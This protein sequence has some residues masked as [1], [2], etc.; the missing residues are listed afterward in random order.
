MLHVCPRHH[1]NGSFQSSVMDSYWTRPRFIH[2][3]PTRPGKSTY[4]IFIL[5]SSFGRP[6][7]PGLSMM[8]SIVADLE[9]A[10]ATSEG[11][12]RGQGI[13]G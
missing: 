1:L 11:E 4:I 9:T 6:A 12:H 8:L 7:A 10:Q 13:L 5:C 2:R 3:T